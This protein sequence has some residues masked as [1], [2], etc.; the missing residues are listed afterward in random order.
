MNRL[1]SFVLPAFKASFFK[2]AIDSIL[3]QTYTNFELIIV[4][5]ASPE[6]LDSIVES[7]NDPRI[8]YFKNTENIGGKD[9]VAQWNKCL[10]YA[11]G[12]YIILASDDDLYNAN[13][14]AEMDR[15]VEMYP[16]VN[17]IKPRICSIDASGKIIWVE[18]VMKEYSS[19]FEFLYFKNCNFILSGIPYFV[20]K[21]EVLLSIDGFVNYPLA[22]HSDD[23]T[24]AIMAQDGV[25]S[26]TNIL[27]SFRQSGENITSKVN[28]ANILYKK[29]CATKKYYD[30][31]TVFLANLSA[32]N[33]Y[34][35]FYKAKITANLMEK[36]R[37][38]CINWTR[39]SRISAIL[40]NFRFIL[41][42]QLIPIFSLLRI[43][44]KKLFQR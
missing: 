11:M 35:N 6:D 26:S 44:I 22:W 18:S 31:Y 36:K 25:A 21:K 28:D 39:S 23:A 29:L 10:K 38:D 34:D 2:E 17:V 40:T 1:Y 16:Q 33:L 32:N 12:E 4:N 42:S 24:I 20:L 19:V 41:K 43:V 13:Y 30:W 5:D 8:Q 15:L 27:F 3:A 14:L 9:L 7:Y 37:N